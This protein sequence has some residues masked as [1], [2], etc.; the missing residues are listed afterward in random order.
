M[1]AGRSSEFGIVSPGAFGADL[2]ILETHYLIAS[3]AI[4][5]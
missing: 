1:R 4:G 5:S 3:A 2:E